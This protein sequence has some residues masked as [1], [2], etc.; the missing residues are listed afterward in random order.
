[1]LF[2]RG[3]IKTIIIN[4]ISDIDKNLSGFR[5][6]ALFRGVSNV[7]Y[8]LKPSLFRHDDLG[9]VNVR[10]SNLM[11]LFKTSAKGLLHR[12]P[13]SEVEW[14]VVAQHHGLPTRLLDW[15]LSPLVACFFAVQSLSNNDGV[16]YIYDPI[17][18]INEDEIDLTSFESLSAFIPSHV[19]QRVTAQSGMF[20]IH[21][22]DKILLEDDEKL[23][24]LLI[25]A[26]RKVE[27]LS[28]LVKYGIHHGTMF[29]D[30]D[31]LSNYIKY[32]QQY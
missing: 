32:Q 13:S 21:S 19:S 20:T 9:D 28:R 23:T 14:L 22:N 30:L 27:I 8:E 25:P 7:G 15:S 31:G 1:L 3:N 17:G 6:S 2:I 10:E 16:I 26:D 12:V 5:Q 4:S 18:F 24:K 29:P 11:W